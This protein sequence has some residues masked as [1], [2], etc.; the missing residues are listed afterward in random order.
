MTNFL[1]FSHEEILTALG[2]VEERS[3]SPTLM[4][5]LHD[6]GPADHFSA[7]EISDCIK[8]INGCE[9][10]PLLRALKLQR[11]NPQDYGSLTASD[12]HDPRSEFFPPPLVRAAENPNPF[13][14]RA[15][16]LLKKWD[17]SKWWDATTPLQTAI[18]ARLIEN[19]RLLLAHG[20]DANGVPLFSIDSWSARFLRFRGSI[21]KVQ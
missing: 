11:S 15:L 10:T 3:H 7:F 5:L 17:P 19:V 2:P 18:G 4:A 20:A 16:L 9:E 6:S 8:N 1:S 21:F 12:L 14:L 13:I